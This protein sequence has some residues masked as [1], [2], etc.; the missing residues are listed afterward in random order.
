MVGFEEI[1]ISTLQPYNHEAVSTKT[2]QDSIRRMKFRHS[3]FARSSLGHPIHG[4]NHAHIAAGGDHPSPSSPAHYI[5]QLVISFT[6]SS[7]LS[8]CWCH[9]NYNKSIDNPLRTKL[10]GEIFAIDW[11]NGGLSSFFYIQMVFHAFL[12]KIWLVSKSSID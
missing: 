3:Q 11:W 1:K 7:F 6:N 5:N 12:V 4:T 9:N 8:L 10:R 2:P